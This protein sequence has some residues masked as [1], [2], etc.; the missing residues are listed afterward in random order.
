MKS[1]DEQGAR[2]VADAEGAPPLNG[3]RVGLF[4]GSFDPVHNGHLH[5]ADCALADYKLDEIIL[6]PAAAPPHKNLQAVSSFWH[7]LAMLQLAIAGRDRFRVSSVESNLPA[8]SYTIDTLRYFHYQPEHRHD[9]FFFIIGAD[10]F[11]E[12][13]S[14]KSYRQVLSLTSFIVADRVGVTAGAIPE[15]LVSLGYQADD[16]QA[17]SWSYPQWSPKVFLMRQAVSDISSSTI[18]QQL[19]NRDAAPSL[20]PTAVWEY[21]H[22]HDLYVC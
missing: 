13:E 7:R 10:A 9:E 8:P 2:G 20:I 18:R 15:T 17:R 12:I 22:Q 21:I 11:V 1:R 4:G 3:K 5:I 6:I 16:E 14:W 19:H